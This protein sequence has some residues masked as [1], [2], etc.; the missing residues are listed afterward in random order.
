MCQQAIDC[1]FTLNIHAACAHQLTKHERQ[2]CRIILKHH[3][4]GHT[5]E[6]QTGLQDAGKALNTYIHPN[7]RATQ[8]TTVTP[9][10]GYL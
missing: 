2:H 10:R 6:K 8:E 9:E 3:K 5:P 7:M 4:Q 1:A